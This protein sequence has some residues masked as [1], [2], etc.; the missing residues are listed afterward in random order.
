MARAEA[1]AAH[2]WL[3]R[4]AE[5]EVA[6]DQTKAK[7]SVPKLP[8]LAP[9]VLPNVSPKPLTAVASTLCTL[10]MVLAITGCAASCVINVGAWLGHTYPTWML[11]ALHL[12]VFVVFLPASLLTSRHAGSAKN[13]TTELFRQNGPKGWYSALLTYAMVNF[14]AALAPAFVRSHGSV[15]RVAMWRAFSGHW[16]TFYGA[17]ALM[18]HALLT[19]TDVPRLLL[20]TACLR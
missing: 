5:L 19:R 20:S 7:R 9:A 12:G 1:V 6:Y 17:A 4:C 14:F 8:M 16:I 10:P 2:D 15:S 13:V 3:Q 18:L 11:V